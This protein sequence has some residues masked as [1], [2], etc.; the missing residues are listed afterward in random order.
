MTTQTITL[1]V[2]IK[3]GET[4][5]T[6]ITLR[7]PMGGALRGVSLRE[8]LDMDTASIIKV[9]SRVSEPTLSEIELNTVV[10]PADLL[11]M[12]VALSG[13][14]LPKAIKAAAEQSIESQNS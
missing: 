4:E 7:K 9:V 2:P 5:I 13:F 11:Q 6:T 14:L 10:D 1:D 8:L 3:R 12:G